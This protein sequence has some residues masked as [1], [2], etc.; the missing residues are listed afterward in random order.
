MPWVG[1]IL[2]FLFG[3]LFLLPFPS[4]HALVGL[5]TSASVLM[6]AAAP[7]SLGA[8]RGQ[9]PEASRPYR[10][11]GAAVL[12]PA[13]FVVADL[14]IYWSGFQ[15]VWKLGIV[16]AIGYVL[17]GISMAL[18]KQ[19]PPLDWKSAIWLPVWLIGLGVISWQGQYGPDNTGRI[20]FWWDMLIV[21]L[22]SLVIYYWA[23]ATKLPKEEMLNLVERQ[24][25]PG[26]EEQIAAAE[27][28]AA[29]P[30][31]G[32]SW[33]AGSSRPQDHRQALIT[34]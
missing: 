34:R 8:F 14:L 27:H 22:F 12:A 20:P 10:L 15:V 29:T 11:P 33:P 16:L 31:P 5:A 18:D 21:A 7:L 26:P 32:S 9:V 2:A 13:A 17:I 24:A 30:P 23:M 25:A 6:Y 19:R 28:G 1:I 3:L 4:W